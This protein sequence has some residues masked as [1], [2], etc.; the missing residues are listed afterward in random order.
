MNLDFADE[1]WRYILLPLYVYSYVFDGRTYQILING[2]NGGITGQ[3][4]VDWL[5]VW[6]VILALLTPGFALGIVGVVTL[7]FAGFGVIIGGFG[8]ILLVIGIIAAVIIFQKA[9]G[10]DDA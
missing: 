7:F 1:A 8:F 4:P 6:L 3:R 2:Q 9:Q 5:K 10:L